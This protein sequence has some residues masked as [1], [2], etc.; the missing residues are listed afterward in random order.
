MILTVFAIIFAVCKLGDIKLFVRPLY[1]LFNRIIS[2]CSVRFSGSFYVLGLCYF[3][4]CGFLNSIVKTIALKVL[5]ER[6]LLVM[7][8]RWLVLVLCGRL[9]RVGVKQNHRNVHRTD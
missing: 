6:V 4:V 5:S 3:E 9:A 2:V 1:L 7:V 8:F